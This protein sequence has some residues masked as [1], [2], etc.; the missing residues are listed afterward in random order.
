MPDAEPVDKYSIT[1]GEDRDDEAAFWA[2]FFKRLKPLK[3]TSDRVRERFASSFVGEGLDTIAQ[4]VD[5]SSDAVQ[6]A[7]RRTN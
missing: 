6:G 3:E 1:D 2:G 4:L 7:T 5:D